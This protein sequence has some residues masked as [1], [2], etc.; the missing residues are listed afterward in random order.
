MKHCPKCKSQTFT[1]NGFGKGKQNNAIA[2]HPVASISPPTRY[3]AAMII[4][5]NAKP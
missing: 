4:T 3:A 2:A 5:P 1:K